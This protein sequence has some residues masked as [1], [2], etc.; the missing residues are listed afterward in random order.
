MVTW[1]VLEPLWFVEATDPAGNPSARM[2]W[3]GDHTGLVMMAGV[4]LVP[5]WARGSGSVVKVCVELAPST[6]AMRHHPGCAMVAVT[7]TE[8]V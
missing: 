8:I 1:N 5:A 7:E 2:G 4:Q 6:S 3:V